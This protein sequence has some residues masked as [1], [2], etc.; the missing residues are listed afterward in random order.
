MCT[1]WGV[2]PKCHE[3]CY[4]LFLLNMMFLSQV[5][6]SSNNPE[7]FTQISTPYNP[8]IWILLYQMQRL[9]I[10]GIMRYYP[11]NWMAYFPWDQPTLFRKNKVRDTPIVAKED[12]LKKNSYKCYL[13]GRDVCVCVCY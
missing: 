1:K 13:W 9:Q 8:S 10:T 7:N 5:N 4:V 3:D 12:L 2:E 11:E 6:C